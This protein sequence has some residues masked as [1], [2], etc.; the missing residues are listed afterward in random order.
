[1]SNLP[2]RTLL[3]LFALAAL[4]LASPAQAQQ[5]ALP[6]LGGTWAQVQV[7]TGV[8]KLPVVGTVKSVTTALILLDIKQNGENLTLEEKICDIRITSSVERVRTIVPRK[9]TQAASGQTRKGRVWMD[10]GRARYMQDKHVVVLGAKLANSKKD[11]LPDDPDDARVYDQD[12]DG[13]PGMTVH[14]EGIVN[15]HIYL[16]QRGWNKLDGNIDGDRMKGFIRWDSEQTVLDSTHMLLGDS[17]TSKTNNKRSE[18]YF[19]NRKVSDGMNCKT[20]RSQE[21]KIFR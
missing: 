5:D 2:R 13:K 20:L 18:N 15:G 1:M 4:A 19:D 12:R 11:A 6:D 8:S 3:L 21:K 7:T 14:V 16:V 9:F 17:P 10:N